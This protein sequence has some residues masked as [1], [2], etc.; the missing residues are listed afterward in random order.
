MPLRP[1]DAIF[2]H[3]LTRSYVIYHGGEMWQLPR[4]KL[5]LAS[6]QYRQ[7]YRGALKALTLCSSQAIEDAALSAKLNTYDL[8]KILHGISVE[9]FESWWRM[10]G[11]EWQ[12]N[13]KLQADSAE[14]NLSS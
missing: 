10:H 4:M 5:D 8:P 12:R 13:R 14:P 11:F 7:P 1:I 3:Q 6:W 9:K 2:V